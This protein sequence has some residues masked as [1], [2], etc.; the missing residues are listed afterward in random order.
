MSNDIQ[1]KMAA[2]LKRG[3]V[4]AAIITLLVSLLFIILY[5]FSFICLDPELCN[6]ADKPLIINQP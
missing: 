4:I 6:R 5:R 2:N 3:G 1:E